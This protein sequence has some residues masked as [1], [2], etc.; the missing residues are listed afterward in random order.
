MPR[1]NTGIILAAT[2]ADILRRKLFGL[3]SEYIKKDKEWSGKVAFYAAMLNRALFTLLVEELKVDKLDVV[4]ISI[5]YDIDE[6]S[7][8]I[9]WK[10]DTLTIDLYKRM[11]PETYAEVLRSFISRAPEL[12]LGIVKYTVSRIG[13]TFDGDIVY[14]IKVAEKDIGACIV[15]PVDDNT[16]ILKKASVLEPLPA[17][18]DRTRIDLAGRTIEEA[19]LDTLSKVVR[20]AKH[21]SHDEAFN[22][23]NAIRGRVS[24]Q[25]LERIKELEME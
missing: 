25:P 7:K 23:V 21:V 2:Y 16:V 17:I 13:E 12:A 5:E 14:A 10:W 3:M 24:A 6:T 8:A 20:Q 15:T 11:P 19:L 22:T 1:L 9:N 18:F 4:R